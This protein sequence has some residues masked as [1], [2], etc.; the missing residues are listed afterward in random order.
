[1]L[2]NWISIVNKQLVRGDFP[3]SVLII[4]HFLIFRVGIYAHL[5][6]L[7]KNQSHLVLRSAVY[8][9]IDLK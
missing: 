2:K 5:I 9:C 1:M 3:L 8:K 7:N 4:I 6:I